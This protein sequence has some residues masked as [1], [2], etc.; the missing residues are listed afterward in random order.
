MKTDLG[1]LLAPVM[2]TAF[3]YACFVIAILCAL[4]WLIGM[5]RAGLSVL[6]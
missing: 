3:L 5:E 2:A 6:L 1:T 4:P